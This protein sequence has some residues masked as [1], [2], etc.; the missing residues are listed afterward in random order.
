MT[1]RTKNDKIA[2]TH[3]LEEVPTWQNARF[4]EM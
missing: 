4:V 1:L 3:I 2:V